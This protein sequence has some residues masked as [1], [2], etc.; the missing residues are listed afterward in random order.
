MA[1]LYFYCRFG[2]KPVLFATII[3]LSIFSVAI[4][5][6][7][8]WPVFTVLFFM[9]GMGQIS[10]Y[11]VLLRDPDWFDQSSLLQSGL[12]IC[13]CAW[14]DAAAWNCLPGHE[15]ETPVTHHGCARPGLFTSVV[16][17][18]LLL[19][20]AALE[21]RVEAPHVIFLP[22]N[23]EKVASQKSESL[24][25]LDLLRTTNIR[26]IS[27]ILWVIW[28]ST[29][30][31]Y[32]GLSFNMSSLYGNPFFNYFLL[33]VVELP[34]YAAS[35]LVARSLPRRLSFTIFTLLGALALLLILITLHTHS[36][37]PSAGHPALTLSL[38]L[39]GKFG[40]LT[41]TGVL[42]IYTG[43]LSP[44]VIRNTAMSSCATFSRMGCSISPYVL[45]LAVFYQYLPWIVVG[46]LSLLSVL[47]CMFLPET[48][49]RPLP[50]TIQQLAFIQWSPWASTP[51][52]KDDGKSATAPEIICTTHL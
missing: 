21:N 10:S 44:T 36:P 46:S 35:W 33:E 4:A 23:A 41:G 19:K 43:E 8:S 27:L 51:P 28:F 6:A 9:L 52:P 22:A 12:A 31:S 50:D 16:E 11:I 3:M 20:S 25:F 34:A 24:S 47:L 39:L 5:F 18:E 32:F 48:F 40:L 15:L 17:A 45:Q 38:V 42:Y 30:V 2:R 7:P 49:R 29:S 13:L 1:L 26:H 37:L 14:Y